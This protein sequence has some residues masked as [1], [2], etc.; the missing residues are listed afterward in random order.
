MNICF[1]PGGLLPALEK[2]MDKQASLPSTQ[3]LLVFGCDANG[4][5]PED[6]DPMLTSASKPVFGGIFPKI[7]HGA[8]AY[9]EGV[10]VIGLPVRPDIHLVQ[11]LSDPL[12]DYEAMLIAPS[13]LWSG[14][15]GTLLVFV[16]GLS[17]RIG[18][19]VEALFC[20]FGLERN[21][22]GGGAGSISFDPKPC[23][24][25]PSGLVSDAAVL[26][27]LPCASG[28]GVAH[29]WKPISDYMKVTEADRNTVLSLDWRPAFDRYRELVEP[30]CGCSLKEDN[31]F[32]IAMRYPL[33]I[34]RLDGEVVVRDPLQTDGRQGLV[35]VGEVPDGSFVHLLN[36]TVETLVSAAQQ[37]R[38]LAE[39]SAPEHIRKRSGTL[40]IDCISRALFL[41][42][43][44]DEELAMVAGS[45]ELFGAMTL[46]EIANN[47][48]DYL[49]FYNKTVVAAL[50]DMV[51]NEKSTSA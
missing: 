16:D 49:D 35:C 14:E 5:T 2:C 3:G 17:K 26:A 13:E 18:A 42:D 12:A 1:D 46:G 39:A 44:L 50:L 40:L 11:G 10:L 24:I 9:D 36:G 34:N 43:R 33:G 32:E 7:I 27:R 47:G 15:D 21:F 4:W 23:L 38:A 45:G 22:I 51:C 28:V 31:F 48:R 20:A 6:L 41:G 30:H 25:T 19:L 37:A 8:K 29:G